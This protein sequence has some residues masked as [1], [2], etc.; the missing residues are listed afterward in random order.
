MSRDIG[1]PTAKQIHNA[2]QRSF[3]YTKIYKQ[4]HKKI[5]IHK[6]ELKMKQT[7]KQEYQ[8]KQWENYLG[9]IMKVEKICYEDFSATC[10]GIFSPTYV[11]I[12]PPNTLNWYLVPFNILE[13]LAPYGGLLLAPAEG[14]WPLATKWRL[15]RPPS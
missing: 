4:N 2:L 11:H 6:N 1:N 10:L 13:G 3:G 5:N 7:N 14:L 8:L 12:V 15:F 9:Q